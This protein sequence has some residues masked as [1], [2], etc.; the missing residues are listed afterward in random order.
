ME[1]FG[2][3]IALC[4]GIIGVVFLVLFS[5]TTSVRWQRHET[6]RSMSHGFA[7]KFLWDKKISLS[8][9][10]AFQKVLEQIGGYRAELT[11]YER[12]RYEDEKGGFYLY[13]R[14]ELTGDRELREGS[15]VRMLVS[16]EESKTGD[17]FFVGDCGIIVAGG[18]VQ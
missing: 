13:E 16:Q 10:E 6:I 7:E 17:S 14:T 2:R 5:K 4:V 1:A 12:K 18:R 3:T 9:W 15:Y 8:E 11:V